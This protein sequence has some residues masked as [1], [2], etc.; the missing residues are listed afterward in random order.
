[1]K[2]YLLFGGD[3]YYPA[4]GWKDI[5]GQFDHKVDALKAASK[6]CFDWWHVVDSTIG[7]IVTSSDEI[8]RKEDVS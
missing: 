1:M 4:G 5:K 6:G 8:E 3:N 7:Q 2:R